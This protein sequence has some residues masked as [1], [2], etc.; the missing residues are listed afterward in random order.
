MEKLELVKDL[1]LFI[2]GIYTAILFKDGFNNYNLVQFVILLLI[3]IF[4]L[5]ELI[6]KPIFTIINLTISFD[7]NS[8]L[9]HS[10]SSIESN[11][12]KILKDFSTLK[13]GF[14]PTKVKLV[15]E[16]SSNKILIS[17]RRLDLADQL[18]KSLKDLKIDEPVNKIERSYLQTLINAGP[19]KGDFYH[20]HSSPVSLWYYS[21]RTWNLIA[22]KEKTEEVFGVLISRIEAS[23]K[24]K[25]KEISED[26]IEFRIQKT[27][28]EGKLVARIQGS[29]IILETEYFESNGIDYSE[30][31]TFYPK[32]LEEVMDEIATAVEDTRIYWTNLKIKVKSDLIK[33]GATKRKF[34]GEEAFVIELKPE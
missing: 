32:A 13:F 12:L 23:D 28:V 20:I 21:R 3:V 5:F 30:T 10:W 19:N 16:S 14:W 18:V 4:V 29:S 33:I 25:K 31:Y 27:S 34:N 24:V 7:D 9:K 15:N 17:S 8:K 11:I 6:K 22:G 1:V 2:L 26:H